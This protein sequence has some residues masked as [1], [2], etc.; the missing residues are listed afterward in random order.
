VR[1]RATA[2]LISGDNTGADE[3]FLIPFILR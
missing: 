2:R 1:A 3:A